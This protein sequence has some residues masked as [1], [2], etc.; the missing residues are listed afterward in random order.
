[1]NDI[2]NIN[3]SHGNFFK[4]KHVPNLKYYYLDQKFFNTESNS[5]NRLEIL[6]TLPPSFKVIYV[7]LKVGSVNSKSYIQKI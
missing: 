7:Y 1:M 2:I 5:I 6:T 4:N 3:D